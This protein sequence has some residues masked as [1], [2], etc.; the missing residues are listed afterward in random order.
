MAI[1]LEAFYRALRVQAH[2]L[3]PADWQGH[4]E[5]LPQH[6]LHQSAVDPALAE[7]APVASHRLGQALA[8]GGLGLATR[9]STSHAR[10]RLRPETGEI[11]LLRVTPSGQ[12]VVFTGGDECLWSWAPGDDTARPVL[13]G[14]AA[15]SVSALELAPD[16]RHAV[17]GDLGGAVRLW[18]VAAGASVSRARQLGGHS[19]AVRA[20]TFSED[21]RWIVSIGND[22]R[23]LR[24]AADHPV[25]DDPQVRPD[26]EAS[27]R[28]NPWEPAGT[29]IGEVV[30]RSL[31]AVAVLGDRIVTGD[32]NGTL[33]GWPLTGTGP[34]LTVGAH[35]NGGIDD[36]IAVPVAGVVL[37]LGR[38]RTVRQW[39]P[40]A[41][42]PSGHGEVVGRYEVPLQG[43]AVSR[44]GSWILTGCVD[45]RVL[46]S[47]RRPE[48]RAR[49]IGR[50]E[51]SVT[52]VAVD[53]DGTVLSGGRDGLLLRW[54]VPGDSTRPTEDPASSTPDTWSLETDSALERVL[55]GGRDGIHRWD[56]SGPGRPPAPERISSDAVQ[57]LALLAATGE[58]VCIGRDRRLRVHRLSA[59]DGAGRNLTTGSDRYEAVVS[60]PGGSGFIATTE[61]GTVEHWESPGTGPRLLG[62]HSLRRARAIAVAPDGSWA[63]TTGLD[64][65]VRRWSLAPGGGHLQIG[66][67]EGRGRCLA[68]SPDGRWV[69][70]G[71][72]RGTILRW[73]VTGGLSY[74]LHVGRH[75]PDSD[76]RS[77]AVAPDGSWVAATADDGAVRVWSAEPAM[78]GRTVRPVLLTR[79]VPAAGPVSL[80][81]AP[82][83]LLVTDY[84]GGLTRLDVLGTATALHG[85]HGRTRPAVPLRT[86]V[87]DHW[88][89]ARRRPKPD[90]RA[91]HAALAEG[92][93]TLLLLCCAD[94]AD[95]A[96][97]RRT[98]QDIGWTVELLP[99]LRAGQRDRLVDLVREATAEG[100]V[101]LLSGDPAL[102]HA[103]SDAGLTPEV[104]S[105]YPALDRR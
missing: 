47:P 55:T 53:A 15:Y 65:K 62:K 17:T 18:P 27:G 70:S 66:V 23:L 9:W 33:T 22:G 35:E 51:R 30:D 58:V 40:G 96:R 94:V 26:E 32:R 2:E 60:V 6:L 14:R 99:A 88:W 3:L 93:G 8:H 90:L 92:D 36:L 98:M 105:D 16:G 80:R 69:Y 57:G 49:T 68:V 89:L 73:D 20:V 38:D 104:V 52:A 100:P 13:L 79:L 21:G 87:A 11:T 75:R 84:D 63:V 1:T 103:L 85:D 97:F 102:L 101:S 19:G 12:H 74:P 83:G 81:T 59:P 82:G 34:P 72:D 67:L 43:L 46:A 61:A 42:R 95:L 48:A 7:L 37:S 64:R 10:S 71:D 76:I 50:H 77:L 54:T 41:A 91:L 78:D 31:T 44:D 28:Q 29:L 86:V 25:T 24:W 39:P 4:P 5:C 45:G 56:L